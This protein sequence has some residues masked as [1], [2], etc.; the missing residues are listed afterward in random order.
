MKRLL[1]VLI[2]AACVAILPS[3][4]LAQ[5][6]LWAGTT[7]TPGGEA[8]SGIPFQ[9][10]MLSTAGGK[11]N[12]KNLQMEMHCTD[13][14]DGLVSPVAFWTTTSPRVAL[15]ANRYTLDYAASAGGRD[16][17]IHMTGQLGSNGKGTARITMTATSMDSMGATIENCTGATTFRVKRGPT[18]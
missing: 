11:V 12:V 3:A 16:G 4:A 15:R 13:T 2:A 9:S 14:Q 6:I 7:G 10:L 5:P 8:V 1:T 17:R 18:S